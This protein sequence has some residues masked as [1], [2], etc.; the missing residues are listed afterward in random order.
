MLTH[1]VVKADCQLS[2]GTSAGAVDWN[3]YSWLSMTSGLA[4]AWWLGFKSNH[5]K[6]ELGR[7]CV[8]FYDPVLKVTQ[9]LHL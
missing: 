6:R 9:L 7:C 5:P 3:T 8:A 2:A 1:L 4:L